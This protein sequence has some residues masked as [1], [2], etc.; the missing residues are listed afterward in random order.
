MVFLTAVNLIRSRGPDE[1]WRKRKIFKLAAYF[2][3]RRRNCYSLAI[4]SVHRAL[5]YATKSRQERKSDLAE[6]WKQRITAGAAQHGI[7][8]WQFMDGLHKNNIEINKKNLADLAAW[9]P[10]SFESLAKI[11]KDFVEKNRNK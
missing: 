10:A 11:S 9:E 2:Y 1:W 8:Y 5:V 7:E 6:L 3:G 4:R